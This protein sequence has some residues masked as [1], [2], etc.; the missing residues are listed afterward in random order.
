TCSMIL[1]DFWRRIVTP[2][3]KI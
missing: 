2:S 1:Q 3:V